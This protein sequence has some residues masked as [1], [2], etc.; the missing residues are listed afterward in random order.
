MQLRLRPDL[1]GLSHQLPQKLLVGGTWL[2]ALA[3]TAW[4]L[5]TW[6]WRLNGAPVQS[7][8]P[9]PVS[10]PV[11]AAQDIASRQLFGTPPAI[12]PV[13]NVAPPPNLIVMGVSTRWGKLPAYA[14]IKDGASPANSF[15]E[16]EEIAPGIKLVRVLA[17]AIEI[18]RN[19]THEQIKLSTGPRQAPDTTQNRPNQPGSGSAPAADN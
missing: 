18:D 16:G 1:R 9:A 15:V 14:L 19:G 12:V 7:A 6:Y 10:D 3:L 13:N 17:D 2:L 11:A 4:I 5:A 8:R